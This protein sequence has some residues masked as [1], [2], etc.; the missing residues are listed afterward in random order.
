MKTLA[1][2]ALIS[3][4][5]IAEK[6]TISDIVLAIIDSCHTSDS[7]DRFNQSHGTG[8]NEN[9]FEKKEIKKKRKTFPKYGNHL[10]INSIIQ[11]F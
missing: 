8:E 1:L 11:H 9:Q 5:K 7:N 3:N 6:S 4:C 2:V 10:W